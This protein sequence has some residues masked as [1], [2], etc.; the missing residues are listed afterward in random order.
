MNITIGSSGKKL[1][2]SRSAFFS[3]EPG[4]MNLRGVLGLIGFS[5]FGKSC[6]SVVRAVG[7]VR[8]ASYFMGVTHCFIA[9]V[10][11]R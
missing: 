5:E 7:L 9:I 4:V 11:N 6:R 1:R 3:A 8:L 2:R 10:M